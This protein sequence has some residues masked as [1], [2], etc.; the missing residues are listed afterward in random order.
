MIGALFLLLTK[1]GYKRV[2]EDLSLFDD[3]YVKPTPQQL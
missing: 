2:F 3:W 1:Q